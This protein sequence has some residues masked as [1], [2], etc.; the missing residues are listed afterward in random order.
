MAISLLNSRLLFLLFISIFVK[1]LWMDEED[2]NYGHIMLPYVF[3]GIVVHGFGRG[4]KQLK[5]PTG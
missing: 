3:R 5:C 2:E 4:G 1:L